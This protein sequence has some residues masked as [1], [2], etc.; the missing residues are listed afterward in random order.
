[1]IHATGIPRPVKLGARA[2]T[3]AL[4][5]EKFLFVQGAGV[6]AEGDDVM[7]TRRF[8]EN[9]M[10]VWESGQRDWER[11]IEGKKKP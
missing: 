5:S 2:M 8:S 3:H 1:M 11:A 4:T 9:L 10:R 6:Y 7:R